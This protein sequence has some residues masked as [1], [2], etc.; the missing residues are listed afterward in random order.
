VM[1][2][3]PMILACVLLIL[4]FVSKDA[5]ASLCHIITSN[6]WAAAAYIIYA[7]AM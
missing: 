4:S 5:D 6:I 2:V 7:G 3:L 1:S